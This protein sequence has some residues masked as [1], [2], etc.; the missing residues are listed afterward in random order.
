M[1]RKFRKRRRP[2]WPDPIRPE[3]LLHPNIPKPLH[4][5]NPRTLLGKKWWDEQRAIAYAVH[6]D[7][8][9]ACGVHK[10]NA[11]FRKWLEAHEHYD[12]DYEKGRAELKEIVALCNPCHN[13][14][15]SGRLEALKTK[16]QITKYQYDTIIKHGH[17][18]L[19]F[20]NLPHRLPT[21]TMYVRWS[22]WRLVINGK[23]YEPLFGSL[24][25]WAKNYGVTL[26]PE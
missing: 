8:C 25:E 6:N 9:W 4:G 23:E 21:P 24:Q 3:L 7:R 13:Y 11:L 18:V 2:K 17:T 22:D 16:G 15:H 5:L 12:Y 14:I 20:A 1:P 10:S 19:D 26:E